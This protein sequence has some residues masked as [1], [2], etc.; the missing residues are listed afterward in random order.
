MEYK[1][2]DGG[3]QGIFLEKPVN[4]DNETCW[5]IY[6]EEDIPCDREVVIFP[7]PCLYQ[8]GEIVPQGTVIDVSVVTGMIVIPE[9]RFYRPKDGRLKRVFAE[10]D[11]LMV[12][13]KCPQTIIILYYAKPIV[14]KTASTISTVPPPTAPPP[15]NY[16]SLVENYKLKRGIVI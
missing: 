12:E 3:A 5:G 6:C 15:S 7:N 16:Q 1:N 13:V 9:D 2:Y 14:E 10:G 8:L 4:T 11:T